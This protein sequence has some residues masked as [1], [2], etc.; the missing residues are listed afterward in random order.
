MS[1]GQSHECFYHALDWVLPTT[2]KPE[3]VYTVFTCGFLDGI[4]DKEGQ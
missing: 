1:P 4:M 3:T 2:N